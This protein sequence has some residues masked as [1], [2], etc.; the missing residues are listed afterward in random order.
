[1]RYIL[2]VLAVIVSTLMF[3]SPAH[4]ARG[5]V[6]L[7]AP[8]RHVAHVRIVSTS[9]HGTRTHVRFNTGSRWSLRAC[10][11]EDSNNCYW[12]A[13]KRGNGHGRSFATI[14]GRTYYR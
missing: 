6:R 9:Q 12:N 8:T 14:H 13:R 1:M 11:H 5:A 7:E 10:R 4:A 2:A 3:T